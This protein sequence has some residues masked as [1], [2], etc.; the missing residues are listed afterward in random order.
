VIGAP[1]SPEAEAPKPKAAKAKMK[2]KPKS[3]PKSAAKDV[4]AAPEAVAPPNNEGD[5]PAVP[6][7]K[8]R[9][10]KPA[11]AF[12]PPAATQTN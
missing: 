5:V 7:K 9:A 3:E 12:V 4:P 2:S 6:A 1:A 8:K 10:S 11:D